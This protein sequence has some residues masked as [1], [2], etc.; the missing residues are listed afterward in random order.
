[1][2]YMLFAPHEPSASTSHPARPY[3]I[4]LIC[5]SPL[6]GLLRPDGVERKKA[7][8]RLSGDESVLVPSSSMAR[9]CIRGVC[10]GTS[11]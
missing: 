2:Q 1:M 9:R 4:G 5:R 6:L 7:G 3:L 10:T 8:F 11:M